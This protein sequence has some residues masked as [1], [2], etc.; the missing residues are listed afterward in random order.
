MTIKS[1]TSMISSR[2]RKVT[3]R[4]EAVAAGEMVVVKEGM[5]VVTEGMVVAVEEAIIEIRDK[6]IRIWTKIIRDPERRK[7]KNITSNAR[8]Q[9]IL[10]SSTITLQV[11]IQM[12]LQEETKGVEAVVLQKTKV[13]GG[14]IIKK[15]MTTTLQ[16]LQILTELA[17]TIHLNKKNKVKEEVRRSDA[18]SDTQAPKLQ[19]GARAVLGAAGNLP[20][21]CLGSLRMSSDSRLE[22]GDLHLQA[23]RMPAP[24]RRLFG[25]SAS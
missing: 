16:K 18:R 23:S 12:K 8:D 6:I 22:A 17:E 4:E 19:N 10:G 24:A 7:V 5:V 13:L 1:K 14:Q 15:E 21:L 2:N 9:L 25:L 20:N 3:Q 11:M